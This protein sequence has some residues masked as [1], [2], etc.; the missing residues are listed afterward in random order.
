[1]FVKLYGLNNIKV[2]EI[3]EEYII[4]MNAIKLIK[5]EI[6]NYNYINVKSAYF[7]KNGQLIIKEGNMLNPNESSVCIHLSIE[8][9]IKE[10]IF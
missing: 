1:V 7:D 4:D 9:K 10:T 3:D 8:N 6:C 5:R 2:D